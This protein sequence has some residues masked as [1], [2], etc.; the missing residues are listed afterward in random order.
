MTVQATSQVIKAVVIEVTNYEMPLQLLVNLKCFAGNEW[1]SCAK[2]LGIATAAQE[3]PA[4]VGPDGNLQRSDSNDTDWARS[5]KRAFAYADG[6]CR[7]LL[8]KKRL[9]RKILDSKPY[10][11]TVA[12]RVQATT[13]KAI[14]ARFPGT[15]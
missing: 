10:Q 5:S 1:D 15:P 11:K 12:T 4:L 6:F 13:R 8:A 7:D 3:L 9:R 14:T 2:G